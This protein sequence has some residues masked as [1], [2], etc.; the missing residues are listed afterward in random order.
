MASPATLL[1]SV[2][3]R[4]QPSYIIGYWQWE[5]TINPSSE[6]SD[7]IR[8][9]LPGI[10]RT[11]PSSFYTTDLNGFT[12]IAKIHEFAVDCDSNNYTAAVVTMDDIDETPESIFEVLRYTNVDNYTRDININGI[13]RNF[14]NPTTLPY[15][16]VYINNLDI[17]VTI[18]EIGFEIVY[19]QLHDVSLN[20]QAPS[21][22]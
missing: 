17:S 14:D 21:G 9:T 13:Y 2:A 1:N 8:L 15:L 7:L 10:S 5:G 16:Y 4:S 11:K 6:A 19:E 22:E 18:E 12:Y 3:T 20:L